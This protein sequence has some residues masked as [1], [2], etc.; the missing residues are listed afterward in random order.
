MFFRL[1]RHAGMF[2][3]INSRCAC[4]NFAIINQLNKL[5]ISLKDILTTKM[6]L[7][8]VFISIT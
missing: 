8:K 7:T 3:A 4:D 2:M 5:A 6:T 1:C